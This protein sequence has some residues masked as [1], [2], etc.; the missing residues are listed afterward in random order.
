MKRQRFEVIHWHLV[1]RWSIFK[2]EM[3]QKFMAPLHLQKNLNIHRTP[4]KRWR[5]SGNAYWLGMLITFHNCGEWVSPSGWPRSCVPSSRRTWHPRQVSWGIMFKETFDETTIW[6]RGIQDLLSD[7]SPIIGNACQW[8][9]D[10][11]LVNLIDVTLACEDANSNLLRLLLFL[12]LMLRIMLATICYR[13]GSWRLVLKLNFFRL[14]A[15]GLVKILKLKFRQD[16]E[17]GACSAFC[18]WCF[19]EVMKLNLGRYSEARLGQDF[20]F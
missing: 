17:T 11:C 15:Q 12:M 13:F 18:R 7:P 3:Y 19:V 14:R 10:C 8:L 1:R 2:I 4:I 9:T 6:N 20:E 5:Y 16:F